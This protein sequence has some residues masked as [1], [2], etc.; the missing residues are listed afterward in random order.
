M[1]AHSPEECRAQA[2]MSSGG[3][4]RRTCLGSS[5]TS[6]A[7]TRLWP[8]PAARI[9]A[10]ALTCHV[11]SAW[12]FF[13]FAAE[14]AGMFLAGLAASPP[15]PRHPVLLLQTFLLLI[16]ASRFFR[17]L[18]EKKSK[19]KRLTASAREG[20]RR[21][22]RARKGS[23]GDSPRSGVVRACRARACAWR[24]FSVST[25]CRKSL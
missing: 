15:D 1:R 6:A 10:S 23:A 5:S 21:A 12:S 14:A 4:G 25:V 13:R 2:R 17:L 7:R 3:S 24:G 16:L 18:R 11:R 20:P 19:S 9:K 22:A 8:D